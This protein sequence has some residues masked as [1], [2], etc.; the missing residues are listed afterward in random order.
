MTQAELAA[1]LEE[2][3]AAL[4]VLATTTSDDGPWAVAERVDAVLDAGAAFDD[5]LAALNES[6]PGVFAHDHDHDD[7]DFEDDEDDAG[8]SADGEEEAGEDDAGGFRFSVR[9]REDF[10]VVDEAAFVASAGRALAERDLAALDDVPVDLMSLVDAIGVQNLVFGD[11]VEGL[12]PAGGSRHLVV[13]ER[14]RED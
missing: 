6:Y 11:P 10:V 9:I 14:S 12:V 7:E 13:G 1:R 3:V 2:V 4:R 5:V 8:W